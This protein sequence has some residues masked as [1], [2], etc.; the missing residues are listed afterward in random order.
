MTSTALV[1]L[2]L[3]SASPARLATLRSAGV[4]PRVIVSEVDESAAVEEARSRYGALAPAD[5]ALLLARAKCEDV[6]ARVSAGASRDETPRGEASRGETS[7]GEAAD[8]EP[9]VIVIGCDSVLEIDGAAYGKP[10]DP[11]EAR[12]R[13]ER[14]SGSTGVLHTGHWLIDLRGTGDAVGAGS[15]TGGTLGATG[16]T[17]VHFGRLSAAEI[18]AYVATGEPLAVAGAFTVDGLGGPYVERIEGDHHNVV[19][20]SLPLLRGLLADIGIAWHQ[21]R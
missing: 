8:G 19:G 14:M 7:R 16:S 3:A 21:L 12:L 2:V 6:A 10:G 17:V 15:G 4:E 18:D 11:A 20:L 9:G 1:R 13:W 5:V